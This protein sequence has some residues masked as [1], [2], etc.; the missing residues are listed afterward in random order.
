M[1]QL[2]YLPL[3]L[4]TPVQ[5]PVQLACLKENACTFSGGE[6]HIVFN[7]NGLADDGLGEDGLGDSMGTITV[8]GITFE[9]SEEAS[10]VMND[11][12]GKVIFEN[13]KWEKNQGEAIVVDGKYSG[14]NLEEEYYGSNDFML[15]PGK[16]K[17]LT[18]PTMP[19]ATTSLPDHYL[20]GTTT[21]A[22]MTT[23][24]SLEPVTTKTPSVFDGTRSLD[25]LS[26]KSVILIRDSTFTGNK[27]KA[28]IAVD[29]FSEDDEEL[30]ADPSATGSIHLE[31]EGNTFASERVGT[32]VIVTSGATVSSTGN[33]FEGNT[34]S[35]MIQT[36]SGTITITDTDFGSSNVVTG[37]E[38][39]VVVD[40][41]SK[42]GD[43]NCVEGSGEEIAA[44]PA[45]HP[46]G[47]R[48][49]RS[50]RSVFCADK[51]DGILCRHDQR[52]TKAT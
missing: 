3:V 47:R 35:S 25:E 14:N 42:V 33:V 9:E 48:G 34:A 51:G 17:P 6:Y 1:A 50:I 43:T 46:H 11:P 31:L 24:F 36:N 4:E 5:Q 8:S 45:H 21:K 29:S 37:G 32:S 49:W 39:V 10:I 44:Q 27:G 52:S 20:F 41:S 30:G 40:S 13:C 12:R 23:E 28:T 22:A 18:G 16:E 7:N 38:G 26:A 15:P 19:A 2:K